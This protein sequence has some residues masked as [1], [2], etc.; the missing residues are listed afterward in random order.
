MRWASVDASMRVH[1]FTHSPIHPRTFSL[2]PPPPPPPPSI[3]QL[4]FSRFAFRF[5]ITIALLQSVCTALAAWA[6]RDRPPSL[7]AAL[8]CLPLA[9][10]HTANVATALVGTAGL[11]MPMFIALRRFTLALTMAM[12]RVMLGKVHSRVAVAAVGLMIAGAALAAA[13]DLNFSGRAYAAISANNLLTAAYLVTMKGAGLREVGVQALLFYNAAL[14]V[15]MLACVAVAS[16]EAGQLGWGTV[17]GVI[18]WRRGRSSSLSLTL[19]F[20][21]LSS[22]TPSPAPAPSWSDSAPRSS[23]SAPLPASSTWATSPW[24]S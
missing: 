3:L 2:P 9:T 13:N 23:S 16:G 22:P 17:G 19:S 10:I 18:G 6:T 14:A 21:L 1:G 7:R 24:R 4:L 11:S 15:P 12:E 20:S 5:P 8:T